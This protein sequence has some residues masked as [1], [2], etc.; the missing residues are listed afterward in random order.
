MIIKVAGPLVIAEMENVKKA[1]L[2]LVGPQRLIGEVIELRGKKASIQVYEETAGLKVGDPV[3]STGAPLSVELGPGMIG[4]I[5]DG[6]QRPL[7]K[8][9]EQ[10]G[11]FIP[12]GINVLPLARDRR[13]EFSP[14]VA[15]GE[16]V[17]EGDILGTVQE[18]PLVTLK[19]MVP[20]GVAGQVDEI[21][22]GQFTLE[23]TIA[24]VAGRQI[25]LLQKWPV[26]KRRQLAKK[27]PVSVPLV[28]GQRVVDTLFPIGKGGAACVPGP[29]GAGKTVIQHQFAKWSDA[30]LIVYV[31]CGERGNEMTDVLKEFPELKDP[32]SGRPLMERTILIA[33]TSN[34]PIA[35]REASVYTG[36]AIAEYYR[37]MGY[38]VAL[39]ADSTSRWAEALR[40]MSGRLEEM[41]GEEGYPAYLGSRLA[42][43][44]ERSGYGTCQGTPEREGSLT[45]IGSVSPPGGDLSEPVVQNTLRVAKVFW[46]L[47]ETLAHKRHFPAINWLLSYSLYAENL[48]YPE[49]IAE[50]FG[51]Q[52]ET[53]LK[54]LSQEAD[55][56]E[57]VR[58]VGLE[59]ISPKEQLVLFVAKS[60]REDFLYQSAFDPVDQYSSLNKQQLILKI[61]LALHRLGEKA[62]NDGVEIDAI[63]RLEVMGRIARA[64]FSTENE[65]AEIERQLKDEFAGLRS[66]N[67]SS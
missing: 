45:I 63:R 52:R 28:T 23:E 18:T 27:K 66:T 57:I 51:R 29:F 5:F 56:E 48:R 39:F 1:D 59:S 62:L 25:T 50:E 13:W 32:K 42:D 60:L 65:V 20:P 53:A 10:A 12:R 64:R 31:G 6:I 17:R 3:E 9:K 49:A 24:V 55:L 2:V 7:D 11:A 40:E 22:S 47:D 58:L 43:F 8:I 46:G 54:L 67:V 41:P 4:A 61:I 37:D 33:N 19:I 44:Y 34:M 14:V 38:H 21:K 30:D 36:A 15:K 16:Q 35:A 26:R